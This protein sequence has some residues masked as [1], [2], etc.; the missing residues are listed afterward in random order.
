MET[1]WALDTINILTFDDNSVAYFGLGNMPG[2][3]EALIE[4][5]RAALIAVF[6]IARDLELSTPKTEVQR[7]RKR[8]RAEKAV[9]GL[10][11]FEPQPGVVED[12]A[13]LGIPE[14]ELLRRGEKVRILH[15]QPR[16]FTQEARFSEKDFEVSRTPSVAVIRDSLTAGEFSDF[17]YLGNAS[18]L[19]PGSSCN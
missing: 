2:M 5:W 1:S 13:G 18:F 15:H 9:A 12:E 16:D 8:E 19:P 4:H 3:L 6:D 11:W 17:L 7:K 14:P 10:K